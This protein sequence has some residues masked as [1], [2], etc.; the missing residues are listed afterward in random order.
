MAKKKTNKK[1][2]DDTTYYLLSSLLSS[3]IMCIMSFI[4]VIFVL[5]I[6]YYIYQKTKPLV[7]KIKKSSKLLKGFIKII[8]MFISL[9][10][11]I[12]DLVVEGAEI[13]SEVATVGVATP[14]AGP[15]EALNE[16][17]SEAI[18]IIV[19]VTGTLLFDDSSLKTKLFNIGTV[20]VIAVLNVA[21]SIVGAFIPFSGV[22]EIIINII[23]EIIQNG[24]LAYSIFFS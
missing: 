12:E 9:L 3:I 6:F 13:A 21:V 1:N 15:L 16:L 10:A 5:W 7:T 22:V 18:Q 24:I 19:I 23:S 20:T 4:C 11:S 17:L 8:I 2:K 14:V